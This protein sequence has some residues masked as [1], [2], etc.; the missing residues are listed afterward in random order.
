MPAAVRGFPRLPKSRVRCTSNYLTREPPRKD[1]NTQE[2]SFAEFLTHI[3]GFSNTW[4]M[5]A[6]GSAPSLYERTCSNPANIWARRRGPYM[7]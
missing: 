4:I 7:R 3:R 1:D 6:L 5:A 2:N